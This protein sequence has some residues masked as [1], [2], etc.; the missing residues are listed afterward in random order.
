NYDGG[1]IPLGGS[2]TDFTNVDPFQNG[3]GLGLA[4]L[5]LKFATT[6][7]TAPACIDDAQEEMRTLDIGDMLPYHWERTNREAFNK[8]M[9]PNWTPGTAFNELDFG[10]ASYFK[11]VPNDQEFLELINPNHKP[12]MAFGDSPV[13]E[14]LVDWRCFYLG[15]DMPGG[16]CRN[17]RQ[18]FG[19]G[20]DYIA[21]QCDL[22][23][24]CRKPFIIVIGD[25]ENNCYGENP[26][27]DTANLRRN[28]IKAW[29]I[30]FGGPD[31]R[32]LQTL[33]RNTGGEYVEVSD[34]SQLLTVLENI[35]GEI[36]EETRAF[37]SAVVPTVQAEEADKVFISNFKPLNQASVW[38]GNVQAY[39]KPVPID[40]AGR[41]DATLGCGS[42]PDDDP[43][44]ECFLWS[45]AEEI[46]P[47]VAA[48]ITS[49]FG[50]L[51]TQR[52]VYYS[53]LTVPGDWPK[54]RRFTEPTAGDGD[55]TAVRYDLWRG[56]GLILPN[57]ADGTLTVDEEDD[58]EAEAN[59][60][61]ETMMAMK[62]ND[63]DTP[64]DDSDDT[65]YILGD[66]FHSDPLIIG[67]PINT[68]FFALN[69]ENDETACA[70][71]NP[72]YRCFFRRHQKRR[73]I[74]LIDSNDGQVHAID[75]G[76][77]RT[78]DPFSD[79]FDRGSGKEVFAFM[80]RTVMPTVKRTYGD[81]L[82][83]SWTVDGS[84]TGLDVFIDPVRDSAVFPEPNDRQW[85][86]VVVGG[87]RRGGRG[88]FAI[89]VT[90]PD[91]YTGDVPNVGDKYTPSCSVSTPSL[92]LMRVCTG[93]DCDP[94]LP[95][96][97]VENRYVA[98]VGGGLDKTN[99][100]GNWVY[101]IDIETGQ[102]LYKRQLLDTDGVTSGGSVP[103]EPT[104]VD[105]DG[106]GYL[107]RVY[108]ATT[109]GFIYRIELVGPNGEA[110]ELTDSVDWVLP[111]GFGL[112]PPVDVERITAAANRPNLIFKAQVDLATAGPSSRAIYYRP[113]VI[114]SAALGHYVLAFGTGDRENL[115]SSNNEPGEFYLIKDDLDPT[116]FSIVYTEDDL[117]G[118]DSKDA[119]IAQNL[120][121]DPTLLTKGWHM[122][123]EPD[124][125]LIT[126]PFAV[127]G[128][129]VFTVFKPDVDIDLKELTCSRTGRSRIFGV[130]AVNGNG[131][132]FEGG[133]RTR[134]FDVADFVT[135]PYVEQAQTKNPDEGGDGATADDLSADHLAIMDELKKLF[136]S[137]CK[138]A[139]Y[140]LDIKTLSSDTG[141]H[142][143]APVPICIVEKNWKEF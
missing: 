90:Q 49:Q 13:G 35:L 55:P 91:T 11:D 73:K 5:T 41:P 143:I 61:L 53:R 70:D 72:S 31:S 25:G 36:V 103:S 63:N 58:I 69:L 74:L 120:L 38:P 104:A 24:G 84:L 109:R 48:D 114:F 117:V 122:M 28:R 112:H 44:S 21:P 75:G 4:E 140:R 113:S 26:A 93:D 8:R 15:D 88:F 42:G 83:R 138:F 71:G 125:R 43:A 100:T 97:D 9:A 142:L 56:L 10:I 39:L 67:T 124:E 137:N 127:S 66:I 105:T 89:D 16:K 65:D 136:P 50:N 115:W 23:W 54:T 37:A 129:V 95:N 126:S 110:P 99:A 78:S 29:V 2:P 119:D 33:A 3:A 22:E 98:V 6:L 20:F 51:S 141:I 107:D 30:N 45:A 64:D 101:I 106:D 123:L 59:N 34:R 80:P 68:K 121:T 79:Q 14:A 46:L 108:V 82:T 87:L 1:T 52:R 27:G 18:P 139:N 77:Y 62:V 7:E 60:V 17:D 128:V 81:G 32:D 118:I 102:A 85:R 134:W 96:N 135:E 131:L 40:G 92:G 130:T 116:D 19:R 111:G 94:A 57:V 86:T 132:L 76:I 12:M 47:Q 133:Q